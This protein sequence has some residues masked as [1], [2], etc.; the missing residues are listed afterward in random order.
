MSSLLNLMI[1][2]FCVSI[3]DCLN[4]ASTHDYRTTLTD[5]QRKFLSLKEETQSWQAKVESVVVS[6]QEDKD[7]NF[8]RRYGE[9]L[10][11]ALISKFEQILKSYETNRKNRK[12]LLKG[13]ESDWPSS[14]NSDNFKDNNYSDIDG[15]EEVKKRHDKKLFNRLSSR[16]INSKSVEE[17]KNRF[18]ANRQKYFKITEAMAT[19][20]SALDLVEDALNIYM[21]SIKKINFEILRK[22]QPDLQLLFMKFEDFLKLDFSDLAK[23]GIMKELFYTILKEFCDKVCANYGEQYKLI[24]E[25][26]KDKTEILDLLRMSF[27]KLKEMA[28]DE[29]AGSDIEN[30]SVSKRRIGASVNLAVK[31]GVKTA[32]FTGSAA[33]LGYL[34]ALGV[35]GL[36]AAPVAAPGI[37][38]V[39]AYIAYRNRNKLNPYGRVSKAV[40]MPATVAKKGISFLNNNKRGLA[41]GAGAGALVAAP[42]LAP[43]IPAIAPAG[44]GTFAA[45]VLPASV[46]TTA[47]TAATYGT[48]LAAGGAVGAVGQKVLPLKG[49]TSATI[50]G[51]SKTLHKVGGVSGRITSPVVKFA[52]Q[53][54]API[55][56]EMSNAITSRIN[57]TSQY[58]KSK[59]H[60]LKSSIIR[61]SR[62][63]SSITG[64]G[65]SAQ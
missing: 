21:Q 14:L 44:L 8:F 18:L 54:T 16:F 1:L 34:T 58:L 15:F 25:K 65:S 27:D 32:A 64:A 19:Q 41:L 29:I 33:S 36:G 61:N 2:F 43:L 56:Q 63:A 48:G 53:Q 4:A 60:D 47:A 9:Y 23:I 45:T 10:P 51:V 39:A 62:Q 13:M 7:I 5:F 6:L 30:I 38:A 20:E 3:Q 12:K 49:M 31:K 35:G 46:S 42:Y 37:A 22:W 26:N 24:L 52:K 28:N 59:A 11:Q 57:A 17:I 55:K 40:F 50:S